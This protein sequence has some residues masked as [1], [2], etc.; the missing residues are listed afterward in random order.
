L[1][2]LVSVGVLGVVRRLLAGLAGGRGSLDEL[3][4]V[5]LFAEPLDQPELRLEVVD[6]VFL[7]LE[8]ALE[9]VGRVAG[10]SACP[11]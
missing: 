11:G 10:M 1:V 2:L 7:V 9:E 5:G 8:D 6:V 3:G 4:E